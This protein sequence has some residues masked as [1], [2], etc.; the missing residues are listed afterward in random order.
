MKKRGEIHLEYV[1]GSGVKVRKNRVYKGAVAGLEFK[2]SLFS[3]WLG[4]KPPST[5]L[6]NKLLGKV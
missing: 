4:T 3:I 5:D 2:K 1:P 6:K